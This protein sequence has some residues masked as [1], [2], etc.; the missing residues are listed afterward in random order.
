MEPFLLQT[1]EWTWA[2]RQGAGRP[3]L[4]VVG[5]RLDSLTTP[6]RARD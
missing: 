4:G 1:D 6:G 5:V 3:L 2:I